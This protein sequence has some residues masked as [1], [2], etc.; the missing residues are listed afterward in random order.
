[1]M[2]MIILIKD[3]PWRDVRVLFPGRARCFRTRQVH[4]L[5]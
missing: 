2:F 4:Q 1:M 3:T 5:H